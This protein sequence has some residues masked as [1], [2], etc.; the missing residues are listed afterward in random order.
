LRTSIIGRELFHYKSLLEW[1]LSQERK[2]VKGFRRAFYSGVTTNHLAEVI[3]DVILLHP[4][5][6]GIYQV[7]SQTISKYELLLLLRDAYKLDVE[8]TPDETFHCDRSMRGDR[9]RLATGYIC[10]PWPELVAQ[11]ANDT[12]PY[13]N[14]RFKKEDE[15]IRR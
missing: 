8:I 14:W 15:A 10:R 3:A 7:T 12:T 6:S 5:L 2:Q 1:F 4:R 11:L 13:G 9:F